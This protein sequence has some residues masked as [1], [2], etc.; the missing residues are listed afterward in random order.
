MFLERQ[1]LLGP[2]IKYCVA[3][4]EDDKSE[5]IGQNTNPFDMEFFLRFNASTSINQKITQ[6]TEGSV[7]ECAYKFGRIRAYVIFLG[8]KECTLIIKIIRITMIVNP[9]ELGRFETYRNSC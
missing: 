2:H 7:E 4:N 5:T 9:S 8:D 3:D 6:I 1:I